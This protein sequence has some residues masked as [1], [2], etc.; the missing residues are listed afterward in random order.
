MS[1]MDFV[2]KHSDGLTGLLIFT[3]FYVLGLISWFGRNK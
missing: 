3:M 1:L 2:D